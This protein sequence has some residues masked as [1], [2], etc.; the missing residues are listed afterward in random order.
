M[1]YTIREYLKFISKSSNE[2]GVHSPFVYN[3]VTNCLYK[4]RNNK[5][6]KIFY[7]SKEF[8]SK[9]KEK[10]TVKEFGTGSNFFK[11]NKLIFNT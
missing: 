1:I 11:S 7:S 10:I 4:K 8:L 9:N 3:L 6:Q 2:H 5:F